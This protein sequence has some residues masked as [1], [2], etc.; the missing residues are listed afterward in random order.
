MA[1]Q[2]H[3]AS[4]IG[5]Q[6]HHPVDRND[7]CDGNKIAHQ[8]EKS[9]A[10]ANADRDSQRGGEKTRCDQNKCR[11]CIQPRRRQD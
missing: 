5:A 3:C 2:Y 6:L 8:C 9:Y 1:A 4:D 11:P 7:G 10:A